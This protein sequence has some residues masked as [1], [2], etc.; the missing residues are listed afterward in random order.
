MSETSILLTLWLNVDSAPDGWSN[1]AMNGWGFRP[2]LCTYRLDSASSTSLG[3]ANWAVTVPNYSA[4]TWS[5]HELAEEDLSSK[6]GIQSSRYTQSVTHVPLER[7]TWGDRL[8]RDSRAYVQ[9]GW[10]RRYL[11]VY[12]L[13]HRY[14]PPLLSLY[15]VRYYPPWFVK[16]RKDRTVQDLTLIHLQQGLSSRGRRPRLEKPILTEGKIPLSC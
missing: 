16:H 9:L 14:D 10:S 8:T 2:Y 7:W 3:C 4:S 5:E 11:V 15:Q 6:K 13:I 1:W 12:S